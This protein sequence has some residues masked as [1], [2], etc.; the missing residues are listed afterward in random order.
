M[1][2]GGFQESFAF[3]LKLVLGLN[4]PYS[5]ATICIFYLVSIS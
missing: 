3:F 4:E 2:V 5:L 1:G